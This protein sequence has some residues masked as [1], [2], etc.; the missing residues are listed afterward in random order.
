MPVLT[1]V[2]RARP[3]I[4][5]PLMPGFT[6]RGG[7]SREAR[8][9]LMRMLGRTPAEAEAAARA[10]VTLGA[11][12][13]P[14]PTV[15]EEVY[16]A[17]RLAEVTEKP[18][19]EVLRR[20]QEEARKYA[21]GI[22]RERRGYQE[23]R[24]EKARG[25]KK[26]AQAK[27]AASRRAAA[28][29]YGVEP[30]YLPDIE[31]G[32][33]TIPGAL[34]IARARK[35][36]QE[37]VTKATRA[38]E[39][40]TEAERMYSVLQPGETPPSTLRQ[41]GAGWQNATEQERETEAMNRLRSLKRTVPAKPKEEDE[42]AE[43]EKQLWALVNNTRLARPV[44][45]RAARELGVELAPEEAKPPKPTPSADINRART[46]IFDAYAELGLRP[47]ATLAKMGAEEKVKLREAL[48][49]I[50]AAFN[51]TDKDMDALVAQ[52]KVGF[53]PSGR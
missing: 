26:E 12:Q 48:E 46:V 7:P 11:P 6:G 34:M 20:R 25:R 51:L 53:V 44:R 35:A 49:R 24:E 29:R 22:E 5:L 38:Q 4:R 33:V 13:A 15:E 17:G 42:A 14:P 8:A 16:R 18:R 36:E 39:E 40:E 28:E 31:A 1:G 27:E 37:R 23:A 19:L 10:G 47:T 2:L 45:Q 41:L 21:G 3:I 30:Q 50:Q 9:R 32:A 43:R 52:Q